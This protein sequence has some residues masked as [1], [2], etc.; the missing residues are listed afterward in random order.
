LTNLGISRNAKE[1]AQRHEKQLSNV[2]A[3]Q[4]ICL[5][6][7]P[8]YYEIA[9]KYRICPGGWLSDVWTRTSSMAHRSSFPPALCSIRGQ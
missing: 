1:T 8:G 5:N 6:F 7:L 9:S 3:A 2:S 4:L